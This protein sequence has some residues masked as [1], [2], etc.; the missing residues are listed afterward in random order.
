MNKKTNILFILSDDQ[1]A[2]AM[3][4]AGNSELKTPNIDK[5]AAN[6]LRFTNFFCASPV[7][8][9]ARASIMTGTIPSAHGIHDWLRGGNVDHQS[10][11]HLQEKPG[12]HV[13]E[14]EHAAI[15]YLQ[16]F[17]TYTD[18]LA[19]NGY[20]CALSGKW[21]LGDSITPQHGFEGW[22]T[23]A[24]G[25]C[26]YFNGDVVRDGKVQ[27][28][29]GYITDLITDNAL[30]V[31]DEQS[32][33]TP[34]Y[35]SVHYTAPHHPWDENSHQTKY[36]DMYRNCLFESTPDVVPHP[37]AKG[38]SVATAPGQRE[39]HLC[40]YFAAITAMDAG[41]GRI[42]NKLEKMEQLE[43]TLI[44][45]TSDNGMN[46]GH[47]GIWG[48]GN[49]T[50]PQNMYDTSVKVPFIVSHMGKIQ[51][52]VRHGLY[53]H[54][55]IFPTLMDYLGMTYNTKQ[56]L[57]GKS[58]A[59][60][61]QGSAPLS[62]EAGFIVIFDEYGPVRMIRNAE[63]KYIH[64]YPYG[65]HEL[66]NLT[67]DPDEEINLADSE[68]SIAEIMKAQLDDFYVKYADPKVDGTR[69]AVTGFGQLTKSGVY[70]SGKKVYFESLKSL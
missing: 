35:L 21:H 66:Y 65:P 18:I 12:G 5:L 42:I 63:W 36:L 55:D 45:F 27:F 61:L 47:H 13:F 4:C 34:F 37:W 32:S 26:T 30:R 50:F 58:F 64:R 67:A 16:D 56:E 62:D 46:M 22:Y 25:G 54:Y 6:G 9:P 7:C 69:E 1:G 53:S 8:S 44:I 28:E 57:V 14:S 43:N 33:N 31:L 59:P 2:W 19:D 29:K 39:E 49:G 11:A 3:G 68:K 23:I 10:I 51:P 15:P 38:H 52:G 41:I 17:T 60:C 48:K 70:S 20:F 24:R 40:G